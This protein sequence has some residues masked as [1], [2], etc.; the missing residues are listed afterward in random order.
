M[1]T[2]NVHFLP[3]PKESSATEIWLYVTEQ[4]LKNVMQRAF[5]MLLE[6]RLPNG[7]MIS[8]IWW[9]NPITED[10]MGLP[11]RGFARVPG[12]IPFEGFSVLSSD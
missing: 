11:E 4:S 3:P 1:D 7:R 12:A 2:E 10:N 6:E 8:L 5:S 9:G